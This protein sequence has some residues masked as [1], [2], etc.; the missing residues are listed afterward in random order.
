MKMRLRITAVILGLAGL[1]LAAPMV[2]NAA[3]G[4][5]LF[6]SNCA[7]CHGRA[8]KG[9]GPGARSLN[10]KPPDLTKSKLGVQQ[11]MKIVRDGRGA[12]PSWRSSLSDADIRNVANHTKGLQ[13]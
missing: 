3:D 4:A 9:D 8:G 13:K 6:R 11:I 1:M 5:T 2:A 10:P 12:C 7:G